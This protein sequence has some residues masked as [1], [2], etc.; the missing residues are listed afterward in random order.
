[1]LINTK[2]KVDS[3]THMIQF[4]ISFKKLMNK[5]PKYIWYIT[6]FGVKSS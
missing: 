5:P 2:L 4:K 1:M 3:E 6:D